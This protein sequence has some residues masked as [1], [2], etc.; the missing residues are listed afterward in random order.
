[1]LKVPVVDD[2]NYA[3]AD[4]LR[5]YDG[6]GAVRLLRHDPV[7][8]ALLLERGEP[9]TA[10][11][12][13]PD[14]ATAVEV[15]CGLLRRLRRPA[16]AGVRFPSATRLA[17]RWAQEL[18]VRQRRRRLPGADPLVARAV[19]LA[20]RYADEPADPPLLINR[21][22][23]LGN[24]IRAEREPWLLIDPKPL[25]GEAAFEAGH[26]VLNLLG[27][28]PT[29]HRASE[30]VGRLAGGLDVPADRVRGWA[31]VRAVENA[32]WEPAGQSGRHLAR[33]A[34]LAAASH[35]RDAP[36]PT[37]R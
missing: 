23:H 33:A 2:E 21:D 12:D 6:D 31:L 15:F 37:Q 10:L 25:V 11:E 9:G 16:P 36:A 3:E 28:S 34:A 26:P 35:R 14:R 13:E 18:P 7:S 19:A 1:M 32:L 27:D 29:P 20:H 24:V 5:A 30:V 17:T 22:A 8:G 4:G